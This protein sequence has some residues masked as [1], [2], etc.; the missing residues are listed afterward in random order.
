MSELPGL[1]VPEIAGRRVVRRR[2][3]G[4]DR[5][6][7]GGGRGRAAVVGRGHDHADRVAD[8][9]AGQRVGVL[10]VSG[11]G[12]VLAV[13][14]AVLPLVV[15]RPG[16]RSSRR[17]SCVSV[18]PGVVV[19]EIAGSVLFDGGVDVVLGDLGELGAG[20]LDVRV[21]DLDVVVAGLGVRVVGG[22]LVLGRVLLVA[23]EQTVGHHVLNPAVV[24]PVDARGLAGSR[25]WTCRC[26]RARSGAVRCR[27]SAVAV[28][29][30]WPDWVVVSTLLVAITSKW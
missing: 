1:G 30:S 3:P 15:E 23:C 14:V 16:R 10:V 4:D 7:V 2:R 6:W 9:A 24:A 13:L 28:V 26:R 8:V 17:R 22:Q 21:G 11:V 20:L 27:R 5:R 18:C 29:K 19:P 12:A 25:S